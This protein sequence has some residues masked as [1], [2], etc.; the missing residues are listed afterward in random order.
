M[1]SSMVILVVILVSSVLI[2]VSSVIILV[3]LVLKRFPWLSYEYPV[4]ILVS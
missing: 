1:I 2:L 3:S 4:L